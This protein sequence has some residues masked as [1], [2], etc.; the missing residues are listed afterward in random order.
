MLRDRMRIYNYSFEGDEGTSTEPEALLEQ[1]EAHTSPACWIR[2]TRPH[3]FV[4]G[5]DRKGG[6][7][8]LTRG[9]RPRL[10]L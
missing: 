10:K 5:D 9:P 4:I 6:E 1:R 8:V 7:V 3:N 2:K